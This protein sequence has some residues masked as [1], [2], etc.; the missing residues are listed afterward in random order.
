MTG[1]A[2]GDLNRQILVEKHSGTLDA[3]NQ[4]LDNNWITHATVW[5]NVKGQTGMGSLKSSAEGL[6]QAINAYSFRIRY[7]TDITTAMRVSMAGEKFDIID[8]RHDK[9]FQEWTDLVCQVGGNNG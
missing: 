4:P 5:A 2:A 3:L 1:L 7:K 8:I 9:A 6:A